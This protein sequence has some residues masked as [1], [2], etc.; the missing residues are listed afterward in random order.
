MVILLLFAGYKVTKKESYDVSELP[1]KTK[2]RMPGFCLKDYLT[3]NYFLTS[4]SSTS[5]TKTTL[6]PIGL[7]GGGFC[8]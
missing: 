8:P 6:G 7:L 5:K 4:R 3:V 1:L 2:P